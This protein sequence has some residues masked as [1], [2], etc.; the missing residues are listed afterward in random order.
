[1]GVREER[2]LEV[3]GD[4]VEESSEVREVEGRR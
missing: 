1:M 4:E 2:G 3:R